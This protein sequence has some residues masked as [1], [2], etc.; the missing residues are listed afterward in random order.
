MQAYKT[1]INDISTCV[2]KF[3]FLCRLM[4]NFFAERLTRGENWRMRCLPY[5]YIVGQPKCGTTDLFF[6]ISLH[7]DIL[8]GPIKEPQFWT[9][10]R[11]CTFL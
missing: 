9:R 11:I 3:I 2:L 7:P 6:K 4:E 1:S 10:R 8:M 5:F